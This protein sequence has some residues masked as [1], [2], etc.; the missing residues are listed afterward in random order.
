MYLCCELLQYKGT[1][2][3]MSWR[4]VMCQ[5]T[6]NQLPKFI[7]GGG[8]PGESRGGGGPGE[9]RGGRGS[10]GGRWG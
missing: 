8:G 2:L 1:S 7:E 4:G 10:R 9:S 6:Q 5:T 3:H